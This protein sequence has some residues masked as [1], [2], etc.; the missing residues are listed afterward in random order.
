M[1]KVSDRQRG[2]GLLTYLNAA[3]WTYDS[4][5]T[6][7]YEINHTTSILF[8]SLKFHACKP[9]YVY[10]RVNKMRRSALNV[11]LVLIDM[12]NYN[13]LLRELYSSVPLAMVLCRSNEECSL[14]LRGFD[15]ANRRSA[16]VLRRRESGALSFLES[17][18][19]INKADSRSIVSAVDTLQDLIRLD[20]GSLA[21]IPGI[22][23]VKA[24]GIKACL[25][26]PFK[27]QAAKDKAPHLC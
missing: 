7:D 26:M 19:S 2:N 1:I 23:R 9:E 17:F 13:L 20:E 10:K 25:K 8:L 14:Y 16:D 24:A 6:A 22:G 5:I 4:R 15:V 11:L 3:I 12:P 18:P 21:D 27:G